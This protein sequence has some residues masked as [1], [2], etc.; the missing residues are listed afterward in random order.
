VSD[1]TR[2][3]L[4]WQRVCSADKLRRVYLAPSAEFTPAPDAGDDA[5]RR[6]HGL[7]R[8]YVLYVGGYDA[9]KN[10]GTLVDAF[11]RAQLDGHD[12]VVVAAQSDADAAL[13]ASWMQRACAPR[14]HCVEAEPHELPALY[15]GATAFVNPSRWESFGFQLVEAMATGTPL[16]AARRTAIPEIVGEAALLFEPSS[17]VE[18][19]ALLRIVTTDAALRDDLRTRGLRRAAAFDWTTVADETVDAYRRAI[20]GTA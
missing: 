19:A 4:I 20:G 7:V 9:H 17:P 3:E 16:L 12:L 18:L 10:V 5:V 11:D 6:R 15:R 13:R 8:P 14:L 1:T 2:E